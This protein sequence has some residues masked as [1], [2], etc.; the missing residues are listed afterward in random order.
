MDNNNF[1]EIN[2]NAMNLDDDV[3]ET[4]M[5]IYELATMPKSQFN[6]NVLRLQYT[7]LLR[8]ISRKSYQFS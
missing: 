1:I 8:R 6:S 5:I 4:V 2:E 3:N 7:C